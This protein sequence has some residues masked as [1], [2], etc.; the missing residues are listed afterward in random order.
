MKVSRVVLLLLIALFAISSV[1]ADERYLAKEDGEFEAFDDEEQQ[2]KHFFDNLKEQILS[3]APLDTS[4]KSKVEDADSFHELRAALLNHEDATATAGAG[5]T[6][7]SDPPPPKEFFKYGFPIEDECI[8]D[9]NKYWYR[10]VDGSCNWL[11]KGESHIGSAGTA[12]QRDTTKLSYKDG[13]SAPREGPNSRLLSNL[14]FKNNNST[15]YEHTPYLVGLIEFIIH[16][17]SFTSQ[18]EEVYNI[19]VPKCDEF[20]DKECSGTKKIPFWRTKP[21]AGTGTDPSNPRQHA[22]EATTWFDASPLYGSKPEVTVQLRTFKNGKLITQI[23][24][25]GWEYP[26]FNTFNLTM[27]GSRNQANLFASGDPRGNQDWYLMAIHTLFLREHN[28]LCDIVAQMYPEWDDE[29]IFQTVRILVATKLIMI[30]NSYQV[31]YMTKDMPYP[32]TDGFP[33]FRKWFDASIMKINAYHSYPW[34][35]GLTDKGQPIVSSEE[36]L[37]G[38]RFHD[39]IPHAI[40]LT[41]EHWKPVAEKKTVDTSFDAKGFVETGSDSVL[42]GMSTAFIPNFHSGTIEDFRSMQM[43]LSDPTMGAGFD[44]VAWS[45]ERERERG[46]PTFNN[47]FKEYQGK[48]PFRHRKTFDDFTSNP[49]YREYL[50]QLYAT[51]DDV[52]LTVGQQLDED[53]FPGLSI[54]MSMTAT[55]LV[56]I[57]GVGNADRFQPGFAMLHCFFHGNF[58]T[59]CE[60]TNALEELLWEATPTKLF[61][62]A[63]WWNAFWMEELDLQGYGMN[64]LWKLVTQNSDVKCLQQYPLLPVDPKTNPVIC[65]HVPA[66]PNLIM[67]I[68]KGLI[69]NAQLYWQKLCQKVAAYLPSFIPPQVV[70][71]AV[72]LVVFVTIYLLFFKK[73]KGGKTDKKK[74]N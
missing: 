10:T 61:P 58:P 64:S 3:N 36:M 37:V 30:A 14:F 46:V 17:I 65:S 57:F 59:N 2:V 39:L 45:I 16:D 23:G 72:P 9:R 25:D 47:Y 42:R 48:I 8:N 74:T 52:D 19:D 62:K 53:Y 5:A 69:Y 32:H 41:D 1:L 56:S 71:A 44:M 38:Y 22:N 66:P 43:H 49:V 68:I 60:P 4:F 33:I 13:V 24:P 70:L 18:S 26:P 27:I 50:K 54:P 40:N 11:K 35:H 7:K 31:A 6:V 67:S 63:R 21:L 51:P 34:V 73:R 28:R 29:R 12:L 55:S 15:K 20:F